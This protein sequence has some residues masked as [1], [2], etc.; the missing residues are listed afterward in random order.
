MK[1]IFCSNIIYNKKGDF[2]ED[3]YNIKF[4]ST[5]KKLLEVPVK[6]FFNPDI[7]GLDNI[8]DKPYILAGNHKSLWDIPLLITSVPD[9][10]H[11]MAKKELFD[12]FILRWMCDMMGAIS[13]DRSKVDLKAIKGA[14]HILKNEEVLGIFPEGT[15]NKTSKVLLP[16]KSG[17][18]SIANRT[19]SLVVPFGIVGEYKKNKI[20]LNIGEPINIKEISQKETQYIERKVKEL[21][22]K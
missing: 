3:K 8:P 18:T 1:L 15:R 9:E 5:I 17:V 22:L 21:I 11:F 12:I 2:M 10:I 7:N 13:V 20:K 16:F 19:N 14:L 6:L 4:Y